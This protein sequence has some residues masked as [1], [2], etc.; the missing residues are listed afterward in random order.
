GADAVRLFEIGKVYGGSVSEPVEYSTLAIFLSGPAHSPSWRDAEAS[1]GD[2]YALKGIVEAIGANAGVD[3]GFTPLD[4]ADHLYLIPGRSATLIA[5]GLP[6]G[7]LGELH[8][9][10]AKEYDLASATAAELNLD[11]VA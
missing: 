10:V 6:I 2:F 1:A 4:G 7:Y 9:L 5:D 8:P 3:I 11:L